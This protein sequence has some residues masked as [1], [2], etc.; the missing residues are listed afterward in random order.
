MMTD[1]VE[2][3][4]EYRTRGLGLVR[5]ERD[6]VVAYTHHG[7]VPGYTTIVARTTGGRCVVLAQNGI[8]LPDALTS[9]APFL[10]AALFGP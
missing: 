9:D 2:P 6:G 4:A 8:D 3:V 5:Y 10:T 7:G 1:P